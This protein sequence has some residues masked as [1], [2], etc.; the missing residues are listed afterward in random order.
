MP[1]HPLPNLI[2]LNCSKMLFRPCGIFEQIY[3]LRKTE[4]GTLSTPTR[5]MFGVKA[6]AL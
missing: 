5:F 2:C 3:P 1:L 6:V 4:F